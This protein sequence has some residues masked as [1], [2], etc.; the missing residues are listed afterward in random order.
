VGSNWLGRLV[1]AAAIVAV[2]PGVALFLALR[3]LR[4]QGL[5]WVRRTVVAGR[6]ELQPGPRT[7]LLRCPNSAGA[8]GSVSGAHFGSLLDVALGRRAWFGV[9]ARTTTQ[10]Y[11]LRSEWQTLLSKAP[12]GLIHAR[13][14]ADDEALRDDAEAVADVFYAARQGV[15]QNVRLLGGLCAGLWRPRKARSLPQVRPVWRAS[16]Q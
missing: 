4:G 3:R 7:A 6:H 12:I 10:W 14:W 11:A 13:A 15:A 5:P 9:R 2:L 16:P 1:A 8:R